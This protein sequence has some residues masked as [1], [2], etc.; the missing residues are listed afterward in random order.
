MAWVALRVNTLIFAAIM[1][2]QLLWAVAA[3]T[4]MG[5][6]N[7]NDS[8]TGSDSGKDLAYTIKGQVSTKPYIYLKRYNDSINEFHIV[9]SV[10]ADNE[11]NFTLTGKIKEP[12]FYLLDF[13]GK[14]QAMLVLDDKPLTVKASGDDA[15]GGVEVLGSEDNLWFKKVSALQTS[16]RT[17]YEGMSQQ[18]Q[19]RV[20]A[21]EDPKKFEDELR[22]LEQYTK[23]QAK[24][25]ID[26]MG[27]SLVTLFAA[28]FLDPQEDFEYLDALSRR[29]KTEKGNSTLVLNF[30]SRLDKFAG[31]SEGQKA[32]ELNSTQ[33]DGSPFSLSSLQGKVVLVDFWAA[34]CGPCRR[35]NPNLVKLYNKYK[36]QGFTI[37]GVSL[38]EDA[39]K[40]KKAIADDGLTWPQVSDL[41]KWNSETARTWQ[42]NEIPTAFLLDQQGNIVGRNMSDEELE[43]A[44]AQ[45]VAQP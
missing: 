39:D 10:Q 33:P 36:D 27:T 26:S 44:I 17:M 7:S 2:K 19:K 42:V 20:Q 29:L 5:S 14:Q 37:L 4:L 35:N 40:W 9:D 28:N 30:A 32:P 6:C 3:C 21:G 18:F 23:N 15:L 43:N 24:L 45:L 25:L 13:Y 34:W 12:D 16:Y 38:D 11:G 1:R 31:V 8:T 41:K 22:D